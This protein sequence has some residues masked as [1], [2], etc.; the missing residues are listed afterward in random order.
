M[1]H[2]K[3]GENIISND[4]F[5]AWA[6]YLCGYGDQPEGG[7]TVGDE[8]DFISYCESKKWKKITNAD[9]VQAGDIVFTGSLDSEGKKA[10]NVYISAG[11]G[12]KYACNSSGDITAE[13][14][15]SGGVGSDFVCAFR[16]TGGEAI[17]TGFK[18]DL[19]V[20]AMGNGKV[21]ELLDESTNLFSEEYIARSIYGDEIVTGATED[22]VEGREQSKEGIRIKLTDNALRGYV[23]VM[24]GF[25]VDS[26]ISV[27]QKIT[28]GETIGKSLNSDVYIILID[29]DKAVIER[30]RRLHKSS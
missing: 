9:D 21:T 24:Y 13:Q 1:Y 16:V 5:V 15:L 12:K 28:V 27:G 25:D 23:L 20:I 18:E 26:S 11:E 10:G 3:N 14:P 8:G 7:L 30:C 29:K 4:S 6:L 22:P 19:D 2:L 17:S